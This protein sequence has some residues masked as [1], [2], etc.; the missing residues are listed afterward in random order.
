MALSN[1]VSSPCVLVPKLNGSYQFCTEIRRV[2]AVTKSDPYPMSR[3]DDCI[4][5]IGHA[6]YITKLDLLK[7]YWQVPFT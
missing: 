2:N 7:G 4:D 3:V 6:Q 5:Q 1:R